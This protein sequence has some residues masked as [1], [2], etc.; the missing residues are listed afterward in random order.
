MATFETAKMKK[1]K[2]CAQ[3]ELKELVS[4]S[5]CFSDFVSLKLLEESALQLMFSVVG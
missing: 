5:L 2:H 4:A 1:E 3:E